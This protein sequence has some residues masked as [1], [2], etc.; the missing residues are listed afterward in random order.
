MVELP[1]W[2]EN[3]R[4]IGL[5]SIMAMVASVF[6]VGI[7]AHRWLVQSQ[8]KKPVVR[9]LA[10]RPEYVDGWLHIILEIHNRQGVDIE[11]VEIRCAWPRAIELT[12]EKPQ[13]LPDVHNRRRVFRP[14]L[15]QGMFQ[16]GGTNGIILFIQ[17]QNGKPF[18]PGQK[19]CLRVVT[20]ERLPP[21]GRTKNRVQMRAPAL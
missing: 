10:A 6:T 9:L 2:L 1:V 16:A 15:K 12:T 13:Q 7:G 11:V 14:P 19:I 20:R 3:S 17:R 8:R 5:V 21:H 4:I 18:T